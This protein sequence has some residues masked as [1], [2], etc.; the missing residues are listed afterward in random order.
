MLNRRNKLKN[1]VMKILLEVRLI[2]SKPKLSELIE[3]FH[4]NDQ[5]Q[6]PDA[7]EQFIKQI[8]HYY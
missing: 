3:M 6:D 2:K 1:V 4:Q 7:R 5:N 8:R